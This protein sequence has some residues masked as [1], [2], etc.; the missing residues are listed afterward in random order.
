M[1]G[2]ERGSQTFVWG[3]QEN[4]IAMIF[5]LYHHIYCAQKSQM[6]GNGVNGYATVV[7]VLVMAIIGYMLSGPALS[8]L[9]QL[10]LIGSVPN[11]TDLGAS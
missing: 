2:G 3:D 5:F 8:Q 6:G 10:L 4:G 9:D 11:F 7:M 1:G